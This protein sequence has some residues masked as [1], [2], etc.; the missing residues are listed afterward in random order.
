[1]SFS[2]SNSALE[3]AAKAVDRYTESLA[4]AAEL[5]A[6]APRTVQF[7]QTNTSPESLSP[8]EIY[9]NTKNLLTLAEI[10]MGEESQ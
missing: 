7:V 8:S 3:E 5:A 1:M 10:K 4:T 2:L 9:R 6:A